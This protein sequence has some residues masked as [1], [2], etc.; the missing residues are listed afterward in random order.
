MSLLGD[1]TF[2]ALIDAATDKAKSRLK[3]CGTRAGSGDAGRE[4]ALAKTALEDA[5]MRYTRG[6]SMLNGK[7]EP[8]DLEKT[9]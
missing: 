2:V 9:A 8:A 1:I 5:S 4:F 7:F 6:L 3:Q